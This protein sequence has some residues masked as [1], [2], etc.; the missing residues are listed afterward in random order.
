VKALR[1]GTEPQRKVVLRGFLRRK[2][3]NEIRKQ[4][5]EDSRKTRGKKAHTPLFLM[6]F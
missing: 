1:L 4:G 2:Q 3:E 5:R 6:V